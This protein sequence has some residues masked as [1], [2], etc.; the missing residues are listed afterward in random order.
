MDF[1]LM[2][3]I[4]VCQ[5]SWQENS[6]IDLGFVRR[7]SYKLDLFHASVVT[8][9]QLRCCLQA[10][11]SFSFN[12]SASHVLTHLF[13][14][15]NLFCLLLHLLLPPFLSC[16]VTPFFCSSDHFSSVLSLCSLH[17][18]WQ[19]PIKAIPLQTRAQTRSPWWPQT[20]TGEHKHTLIHFL[21]HKHH[22]HTYN[23][24]TF[25]VVVVCFSDDDFDMSR[26]SSSGYSSAEVRYVIE[27]ISAS[28]THSLAFFPPFS[29]IVKRPRV[30]SL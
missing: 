24:L 29:T 21:P 6:F 5:W 11:P 10:P 4:F 8:V 3:I 28:F 22:K 30:G 15:V 7:R 23:K 20:Q 2:S 18:G 9:V 19:C 1:I 14:S 26:Y 13:L 27:Q 12:I 17:T 16:S 25:F